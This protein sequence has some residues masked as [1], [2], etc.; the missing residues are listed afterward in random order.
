MEQKSP[1]TAIASACPDPDISPLRGLEQVMQAV[2]DN[3]WCDPGI[4]LRHFSLGLDRGAIGQPELLVFLKATEE[5]VFFY[6]H[7]AAHPKAE[8]KGKL[9]AAIVTLWEPVN[10]ATATL[11]LH[12]YYEWIFRR[13]YIFP[14][15]R[16]PNE[17]VYLEADTYPEAIEGLT[18]LIRN[19]GSGSAR[20]GDLQ[21]DFAYYDATTPWDSVYPHD[22]KSISTMDAPEILI[23]AHRLPMAIEDH[24]TRPIQGTLDA[25]T[26]LILSAIQNNPECST[27]LATQPF[28][29]AVES[30]FLDQPELIAL[31]Y[32]HID[33][34]R[35]D[36]GILG[37]AL[38]I[39]H[40]TRTGYAACL[41]TSRL[42]VNAATPSRLL[43]GFHRLAFGYGEVFP[44]HS[45]TGTEFYAEASDFTTATDLLAEL[46]SRF[47]ASSIERGEFLEENLMMREI[48]GSQCSSDLHFD[49]CSR[50]TGKAGAHA[51]FYSVGKRPRT[52]RAFVYRSLDLVQDPLLTDSIGTISLAMPSSS[53]SA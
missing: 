26:G 21:D 19:Y 17:T 10:G 14:T 52:R 22:R 46:I 31:M 45:A 25:A 29:M 1:T 33:G 16:S 51:K 5:G 53:A 38:V 41:M 37:Y 13:G 47:R 34:E 30:G 27:G 48:F 43:A 40:P 42:T 50:V 20:S 4:G 36:T 3:P 49:Q 18:L 8:K 39:A 7:L 15:P 23:E 12:S 28:A 11:C 32:Q 2:R 35:W 9:M 44:L 24:S 6:G